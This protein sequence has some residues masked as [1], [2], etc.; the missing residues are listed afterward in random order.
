VSSSKLDSAVRVEVQVRP[1]SQCVQL[2]SLTFDGSISSIRSSILPDIYISFPRNRPPQNTSIM[3]DKKHGH[4][5]GEEMQASLAE[6]RAQHAH[7]MVAS[8]LVDY[9]SY[10]MIFTVLDSLLSLLHFFT[11]NHRIPNH[12]TAFLIH[13]KVFAT[14]FPSLTSLYICHSMLISFSPFMPPYITP[15]LPLT[16]PSFLII[17]GR[18]VHPFLPRL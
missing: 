1:H 4:A 3:S 15:S 5:D 8:R 16:Q 2:Y 9:D 18:A 6:S 17:H 14:T 11:F 10:R 7:I 12:T 13:L